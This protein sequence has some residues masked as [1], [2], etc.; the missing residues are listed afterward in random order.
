M[1]SHKR[2]PDPYRRSM[3]APPKPNLTSF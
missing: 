2:L 3:A 1:P